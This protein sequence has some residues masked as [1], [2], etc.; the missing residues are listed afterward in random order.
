MFDGLNTDGNIPLVAVKPVSESNFQ[1]S[2]VGDP[3]QRRCKVESF[4]MNVVL[5]YLD[6]ISRMVAPKFQ[7]LCGSRMSM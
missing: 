4:V 6:V 5:Q 1:F 3:V 2:M 7:E